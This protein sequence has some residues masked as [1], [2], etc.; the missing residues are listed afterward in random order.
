M[1]QYQATV[2][3]ERRTRSRAL[4][5]QLLDISSSP[6]DRLPKIDPAPCCPVPCAQIFQMR[7]DSFDKL[8][9]QCNVFDLVGPEYPCAP[10]RVAQLRRLVT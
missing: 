6:Y 7:V 8:T 1:Q 10:C 2:F 9:Y 3:A 4:N 5:C